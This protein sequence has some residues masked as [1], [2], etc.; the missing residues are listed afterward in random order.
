[1]NPD[2]DSQRFLKQLGFRLRTIRQEKGWTLEQAEEY[3]WTS[4]RHLQ[5]IETGHKNI[6]ITSLR[7]LSRLYKMPMSKILEGL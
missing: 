5:Q 2:K 7:Q 3:G 1:V 6:S 4:W